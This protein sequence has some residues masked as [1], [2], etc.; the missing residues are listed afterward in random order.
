LENS[1]SGEI[2]I[3]KESSISYLPQV[4]EVKNVT[5]TPREYIKENFNDVEDFEIENK[6]KIFK[7]ED[8]ILDRPLTKLSSGQ[9]TKIALIRI[10]LSKEDFIILDEPTNNLDIET[11]LWL[12]NF[13]K[14][15]NSSFIIVSHD[16]YLIEKIKPNKIYEVPKDKLVF[17]TDYNDYLE[18]LKNNILK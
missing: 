3:P 6:M 5:Q 8:G 18:N 14:K 2:K 16:R 13:I 7:L 4:I 17:I 10:L 12:E 11:L 1:D 9:K 15:S